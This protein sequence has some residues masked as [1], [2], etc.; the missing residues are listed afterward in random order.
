[1]SKVGSSINL[2]AL[3]RLSS[4]EPSHMISLTASSSAGESP[5]EITCAWDCQSGM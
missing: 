2:M 4:A 5:T 1:M 3:T